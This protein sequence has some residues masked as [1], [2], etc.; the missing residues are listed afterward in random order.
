MD[1]VIIVSLLACLL[2][3]CNKAQPPV[4]KPSDPNPVD[5][6]TGISPDT[7]LSWAA[8]AGATYKVYF[9]T[10]SSPPLV[11]EQQATTF[12]PGAL[13]FDTTYY[14]RIDIVGRAQGQLWKFTT[15]WYG[16]PNAEE[17][18]I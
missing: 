7:Q 2:G 8:E 11:A 1:R 14:W 16:D 6:A 13:E 18:D 17:M 12:D 3:G 4:S 15:F 5:G 10:E 9:G